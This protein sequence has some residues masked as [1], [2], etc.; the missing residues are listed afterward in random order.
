M[1]EK[2]LIYVVFGNKYDE[3]AARTIGLSRKFTNLPIQV[4]TNIP[5]DNRSLEWKN[6]KGVEFTLF[7]M[8][9]GENRSIKTRLIDFSPFDLTLFLDCDSFVQRS[10][11][12][13]LFDLMSGSDILLPVLGKWGVGSK[14]L[15]V[16]AKVMQKIGAQLPL[17]IYYGALLGFKKTLGAKKFF[18]LWHSYWRLTCGRDMPPLACAV[19][20]SGVVVKEIF[21]EEDRF[22]Y[23][24]CKKV[25]KNA[26]IQHAYGPQFFNQIGLSGFEKNVVRVRY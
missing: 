4:L 7:N 14:P 8:K 26:L 6:I 10:G 11:V 22:F 24:G 9:Q 23:G 20:N 17:T 5:E 2:G 3:L 13:M 19:K 25:D 12:E 21:P 16:Y 1:N 18:D 15:S